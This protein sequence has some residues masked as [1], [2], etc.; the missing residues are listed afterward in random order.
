MPLVNLHV[1]Q[2]VLNDANKLLEKY[3]LKNLNELFEQLVEDAHWNEYLKPIVRNALLDTRN[4]LT[5]NVTEH[6][7]Q[8]ASHKA[9]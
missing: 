7:A 5:D 8:S 4:Q 1:A 6:I 2:T 3:E 9:Q